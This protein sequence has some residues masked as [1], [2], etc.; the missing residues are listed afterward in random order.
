MSAG[1]YVNRRGYVGI[2][3]ERGKTPANIG[4]LWRSAD[5]FGASFVFTVGHRYQKQSSDTMK[6]WRSVPLWHFE[7][8]D[9]LVAHLPYSCPL[10]GVEL[11][12]RAVDLAGFSHPERAIY[13]LGAEDHGLTKTALARCHALVQLPGRFSMNVAAAGTVVL[14]DRFAKTSPA[15]PPSPD[16]RGGLGK[17]GT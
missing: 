12:D 14:Y 15:P 11:D 7:D 1:R 9:D 3:I 17:E 5:L 6:S 10:I 4:T 13:L 8:I 2:G 16:G